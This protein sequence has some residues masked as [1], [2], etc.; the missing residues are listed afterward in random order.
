[1]TGGRDDSYTLYGFYDK[2]E[3]DIYRML[4]TV[5]GV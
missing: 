3:R 5:S 1:M 4:V 2:R